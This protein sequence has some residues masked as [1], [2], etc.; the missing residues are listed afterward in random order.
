MVAGRFVH[1]VQIL[2]PVFYSRCIFL[3]NPCFLSILSFPAGI[4]YNIYGSM[5][6]CLGGGFQSSED[7]E[8][9][10]NVQMTSYCRTNYADPKI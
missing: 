10:C 3:G 8:G 6:L 9:A 7:R 2:L 5:G 1:I 4:Q